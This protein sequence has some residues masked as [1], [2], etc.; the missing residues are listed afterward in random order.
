MLSKVLI[1][2]VILTYNIVDETVDCVNS[3]IK[4]LDT[5][6]YHLVVV[7]NGSGAEIQSKLRNALQGKDKVS[8]V[9][10]ADNLGFAKG[11]NVGI[12]YVRMNM[13]A[14]YVCCINN[15]TLLEQKDFCKQLE[16]VFADEKPAVIGPKVIMKDGRVFHFAKNLGDVDFYKQELVRMEENKKK[17]DI[18]AILLKNRII[19]DLNS[20]RSKHNYKEAVDDILLHGCC[21]IFT[22]VFFTKLKGFDDRTFLYCEEEL[23]YLALK[24]NGM[25]TRYAPSLV[26]RH[27]ED[28][29]TNSLVKSDAEKRAFERSNKAN[30]L[31]ILIS[32]LERGGSK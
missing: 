1:A 32:E 28:I 26:I 24:R 21:V 18:K 17:F 13:D 16:Q 20:L 29:T 25:T 15:D 6:D 22:P 12:D 10:N 4:N 5:S 11:N 9:Y 30:S 27:L 3:F 19:Y 2:F 31:K 23:L 8:I 7:D 14:K